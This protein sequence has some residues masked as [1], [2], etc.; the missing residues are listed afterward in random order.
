MSSASDQRGCKN[1]SSLVS[2][3]DQLY[4]YQRHLSLEVGTSEI[5]TNKGNSYFYHCTFYLII[6]KM[7]E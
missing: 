7:F 2:K 1:Q 4:P 3:C 5:N 6:N